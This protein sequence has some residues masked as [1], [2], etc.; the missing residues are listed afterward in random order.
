MVPTGAA[1]PSPHAVVTCFGPVSSFVRRETAQFRTFP[2]GTAAVVP[3][4]G[5]LA[6]FHHQVRHKSARK[7][8]N[9]KL[10]RNLP[11]LARKSP[12]R[13]NPDS[14]DVAQWCERDHCLILNS[15]RM[16][17][18]GGHG[19]RVPPR[20]HSLIWIYTTPLSP[21]RQLDPPGTQAPPDSLDQLSHRRGQFPNP[22]KISTRSS[23][24]DTPID[25][26]QVRTRQ[27]GK[28]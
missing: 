13:A 23:S 24:P 1:P 27:S 14:L 25:E 18:F 20:G 8:C 5:L 17:I 16:A 21:H 4:L 28:S 3:N 6:R 11:R 7:M 15:Y 10:W 22:Q 2:H 26:G 12:T 9:G 19:K